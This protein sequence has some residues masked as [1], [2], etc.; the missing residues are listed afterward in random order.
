M[1]F[2]PLKNWRKGQEV[3]VI[4]GKKFYTLEAATNWG[5]NKEQ[6]DRVSLA[7]HKGEEWLANGDH[8]VTAGDKKDMD[9]ILAKVFAS[10]VAKLV[11]S[12][13]EPVIVGQSK[14]PESVARGD[15]WVRRGE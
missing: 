2:Y 7:A 15:P 11:S 4:D 1:K 5:M 9:D 14:P 8:S 6:E 12:Q 13:P 10:K 3:V